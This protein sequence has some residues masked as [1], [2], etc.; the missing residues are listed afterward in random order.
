MNL[1]KSL[2]KKTIYIDEI[3][4][5]YKCDNYINLCEIV[6]KLLEEGT[7]IPIKS[8]GGNGKSPTLYKRYRIILENGNNEKFIEEINFKLFTG[9]KVDYYRN[10]LDKYVEHR[11][12]ILKLSDFLKYKSKFLDI[13][14]SM[15][16]RSFQI[17]GREKFIQKELGKTIIKNLGLTLDY[18][19]Y[20]ET[21]EPLAYSSIDKKSPQNILI[22]EN[23]DTYYTMRKYLFLNGSNIL[24]ENIKTVIYG[25][26]KA[27]NKAFKDF[28]ISVEG[29]LL[30]MENSIFYFGDLDYE[31]IIIYESLYEMFKNKYTIKPFVKGYEKMIDKS[32]NIELPKSKK[33][34]NKNIKSLFLDNFNFEYREKIEM[35]LKKGYYIPQEI[36]NITDL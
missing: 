5:L 24:G 2:K 31:G 11:E 16:E 12:Y 6:G 33:D 10:N 15:N 35:I 22:L 3:E 23:K 26:G 7:I 19:N 20:Y 29:Y 32:L 36:I 34:Q 13:T 27:V 4:K 21:T 25:G 8:S 17:W 30:D 1:F 9:F 28:N 18:L 14:I